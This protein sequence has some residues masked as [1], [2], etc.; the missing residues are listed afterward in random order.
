MKA[1]VFFLLTIMSLSAIAASN[2]DEKLKSYV[3]ARLFSRITDG[4][5][6]KPAQIMINELAGT[7]MELKTQ[8]LRCLGY[9]A[10][11]KAKP[12]GVCLIT[13]HD[14]ATGGEKL[15][16]SYAIIISIDIEHFD[17]SRYWEVVKQQSLY[18]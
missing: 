14:K 9:P 17:A 4:V 1:V 5:P 10:P 16:E 12:V 6:A 8:T 2:Y 15:Q 11:N 13:A 3:E 18:F 7:E